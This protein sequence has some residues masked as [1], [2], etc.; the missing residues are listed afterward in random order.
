L[1][2]KC[3]SYHSK[4]EAGVSGGGC[5]SRDQAKFWTNP[6]F[7]IKL[8]DVDKDDNENMATVI[9]SLMQKDTRLRRLKSRE[10]SSEE[11]IQFR[12]FSVKDG[13]P[14]DETNE[15]SL[16][17]YAS[18]LERV[19]TSGSYINSRDVTKRFR[20]SPGNYVIIPST[21][22]EDHSCQFLLRVF[23]EELIEGKYVS[24]VFLSLE[25]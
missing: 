4:W 10:D 20:V 18:Q 24:N 1:R 12:L 2:W 25:G 11:F 16:K 14:I 9:V 19:G 7:L 8:H 15:N 5:G 23:T 21:Y 13:V 17:L 6:Q 3:T 22:D